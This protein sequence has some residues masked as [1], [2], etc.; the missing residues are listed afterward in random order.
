MS[1]IHVND[2]K[3]EPQNDTGKL[4]KLQPFIEHLD[5]D[6]MKLCNVFIQISV[7]EN[8]IS[9]NKEEVVV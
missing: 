9:V 4:H 1:N 6:Y 3:S 5:R 8:M 2:S 7:K